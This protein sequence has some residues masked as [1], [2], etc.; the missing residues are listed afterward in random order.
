MSTIWRYVGE[1]GYLQPLLPAR[2]VVVLVLV[3]DL[4]DVEV[5]VPIVHVV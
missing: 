1:S 2:A 3:I 5:V 4:A